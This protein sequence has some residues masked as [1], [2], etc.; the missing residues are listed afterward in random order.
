M[1][2]QQRKQNFDFEQGPLVRLWLL[3][4]G[5]HKHLCFITLPALCADSLTLKYLYEELCSTYKALLR[6]EVFTVAAMQ[7][8]DYAEWQNE[9]AESEAANA[10][11]DF[12][13]ER[14]SGL[15]SATIPFEHR[16]FAAGE[17]E[18]ERLV[19][20][21]TSALAQQCGIAL[22]GSRSRCRTRAGRTW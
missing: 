21:Y 17:F 10:G 15:L 19:R 7:Y 11:R 9:L 1:F 3:C 18:P 16:Q 22:I 5:T 2:E 14:R 20:T 8:A 13:Q 4:L 6:G 12:W